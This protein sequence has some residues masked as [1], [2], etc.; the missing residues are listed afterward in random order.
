MVGAYDD[1]DGKIWMDGKLGEA[2][3]A[4]CIS[5]PM[6]CIMAPSVFEGERGY[7][8]SYFQGSPTFRRS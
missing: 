8:G 6:R 2:R 1:R 3:D 4:K 7:N 5:S